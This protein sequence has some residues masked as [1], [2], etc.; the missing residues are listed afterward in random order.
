M[1]SVAKLFYTKLIR[2]CRCDNLSTEQKKKLPPAGGCGSCLNVNKIAND[3]LAWC[4]VQSS[5]GGSG[6]GKC[7]C[8]GLFVSCLFLY[9]QS[10][11]VSV[12]IICSSFLIDGDTE[13]Q[14]T[15]AFRN[16]VDLRNPHDTV[17]ACKAEATNRIKTA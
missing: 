4:V 2:L 9:L 11:K 10:V 14:P 16:C 8:S 12:T 1:C 15:T 17:K 13:T 6:D 7:V 3:N 5:P